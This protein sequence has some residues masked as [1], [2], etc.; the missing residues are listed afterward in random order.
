MSRPRAKPRAVPVKARPSGPPLPV[1][2]IGAGFSGTMAAIQLA[3]WLPPDQQIVLC[4]QGTPCRGAAYGTPNPGHLLN[5]RSANMS[6]FPRQ[7]E[8]FDRWLD[9]RLPAVS[10]EV[11]ITPAGRFASRGL[12]GRYLSALLDE[13]LAGS[14]P[15]LGLR[16]TSIIDIEPQDGFWRLLCADGSTQDVSGV[17]LAIGNLP[18]PAQDQP[19]YRCNPWARDA[20]T[21]LEADRPVLIMGTGLT[22]VD[23]V[24]EM[25][26]SGFTG[27]II[28]VSRRGLVPHRHAPTQ[29]WPTP[30]LRLPERLSLVKLVA[31]VRDEVRQA[32][33]MGLDW[34][35]VID[36]LRPVTTELWQGLRLPERRRFLRHLR[37]YWDIH[38]HRLAAPV[39]ELLAAELAGGTLQVIRGRVAGIG[40]AP[41]EATV[42][43]TPRGGGA[44]QSL[45]VQRVINATGLQSA[46]AAVSPLIAN[47]RRRGLARL[48][49]LAMGL[50]VT[51]TFE[52]IDAQG[53]VNST[54]W[55]LG[56]I[57][58]GVFW[59]SVAV[60]DIRTQAEK[61]AR[62]AGR[63]MLE[64]AYAANVD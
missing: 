12:Y 19:R 33:A 14:P 26:R 52:V 17:V 9:S 64:A 58:R 35:S 27:K 50:D 57:V 41:D 21:G 53:S 15:R 48:D 47:L 29:F 24:L 43:I 45:T 38:R 42:R 25:R 7:P 51:D 20:L 61:L 59:E 32:A 39:A 23:L 13:A 55:A 40:H 63:Q 1:A 56:P 22:M 11:I 62:Q 34:R 60:L 28:A 31:R 16:C 10:S 2:V 8:H 46:E 36:S 18:P 49:P 5:V 3:S 6:A 30:N 44:P 37:P 4:E 54:L